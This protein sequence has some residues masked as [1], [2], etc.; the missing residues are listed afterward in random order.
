[1]DEGSFEGITAFPV[2]YMVVRDRTWVAVIDTSLEG[3]GRVVAWCHDQADAHK[4]CAA[5]NHD[6]GYSYYPEQ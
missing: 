1:M 4:V 2:K 6:E 3:Q 5:L